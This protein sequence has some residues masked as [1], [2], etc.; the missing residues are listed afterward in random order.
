MKIA[1]FEF[2]LPD[3]A[4]DEDLDEFWDVVSSVAPSRFALSD[5]FIK[6]EPD[7]DLTRQD[8]S[9]SDNHGSGTVVDDSVD[10]KSKIDSAVNKLLE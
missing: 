3:D 10:T 2:E 4:T 5:S 6:E 7:W 9:N 8:A 1:V